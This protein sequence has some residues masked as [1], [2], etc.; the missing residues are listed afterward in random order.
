MDDY[1]SHA[2]VLL[3]YGPPA[4]PPA[5]ARE[6]VGK[7]LTVLASVFG[8]PAAAV[9][10]FLAAITWSGCFIECSQPVG[11]HT[12]GGLLW[13]LAIALLLLG[14]VLAASMVRK[15]T[16]VVAAVA[17]PFLDVASLFLLAHLHP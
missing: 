12:G 2:P 3:Q 16:W 8:P 6:T 17:A 13:L 10:A 5:T 1:Y 15:L 14:P 4:P 11:D 7:V 9:V